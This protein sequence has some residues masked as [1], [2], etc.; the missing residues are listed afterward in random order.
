MFFV[1]H[2]DPPEKNEY[3]PPPPMPPMYKKLSVVVHGGKSLSTVENSL[4]RW[5]MFS[6]V[7]TNMYSTG[8]PQML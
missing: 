5:K 2:G 8:E 1:L 4:P 6:T 7:R 3:R